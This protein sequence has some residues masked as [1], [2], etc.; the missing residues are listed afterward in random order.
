MSEGKSGIVAVVFIVVVVAALVI[1][2]IFE[3]ISDCK[4]L[5]EDTG[6]ETQYRSGSCYIEIAPG[7]FV[8]ELEVVYYLDHVEP[9]RGGE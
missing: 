3:S 6:R 7:L 4:N 1:G 5:S 2:V 8:E 9:V